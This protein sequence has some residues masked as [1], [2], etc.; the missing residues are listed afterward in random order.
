MTDMA[1][2]VRVVDNGVDS[3]DKFKITI[4]LCRAK[5]IEIISYLTLSR[6]RG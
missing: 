6:P 3:D 1:V 2:E 5:K 4:T